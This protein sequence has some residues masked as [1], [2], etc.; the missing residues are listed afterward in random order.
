MAEYLDD[1]PRCGAHRITFDAKSESRLAHRLY[2]VFCVCRACKKATIFI[3]EAESAPASQRISNA[4]GPSGFTATTLNDQVISL[5]HVSEADFGAETPPEHL[6]DLLNAVF[7]EGARCL[8]IKCH[9][10]AGTMFRLCVDIATQAL[11]PTAE[12]PDGP[13]HK[14]RRDLGLRLP[15]LFANGRLPPELHD[16]ATCVKDDGNDGAHKG[17]LTADEAQDLLDFTFALLERLYT[18]PAKTKLAAERRV[19]RRAAATGG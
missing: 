6:P 11:L 12:E 13:S 9:N 2:E 18:S 3:L 16:L 19:A 4:G 15:W 7:I 10:A 1:C 17:T 8:A 5:G 14:Q